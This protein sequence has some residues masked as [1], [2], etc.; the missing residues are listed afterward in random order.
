MHEGVV[1]PCLPASDI[2]GSTSIYIYI[3]ILLRRWRWGVALV[4]VN[5][6]PRKRICN[7]KKKKRKQYL[8][9]RS[10]TPT[11]FTCHSS[12]YVYIHP[13]PWAS[14]LD[15]LM[16]KLH[17]PCIRNAA[18]SVSDDCCYIWIAGQ[19]KRERERDNW[20]SLKVEKSKMRMGSI[21]SED[22]GPI[23]ICQ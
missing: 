23:P 10:S 4:S 20:E 1:P 7:Q 8:T 16:P 14:S 17:L 12:I 6:N 13:C 3:Y 5:S 11:F 22:R 21:Y 18:P 19:T 9:H 15:P 2:H